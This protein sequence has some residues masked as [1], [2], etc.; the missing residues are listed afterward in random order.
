MAQENA[1]FQFSD[2]SI[3]F[4]NR[5]V[6]KQNEEL[7]LTPIEFRLLSEMVANSGKV[8]TQRYLLLQT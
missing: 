4:I 7:H 8:L 2:V 5:I 1:L 6:T 3:D